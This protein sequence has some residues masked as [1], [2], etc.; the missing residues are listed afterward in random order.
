MTRRTRIVAIDA[1][2]PEGTPVPE[3]VIET[4]AAPAE[5]PEEWGQQDVPVTARSWGIIAAFA[6]TACAVIGWT[7]LFVLVNLPAMQAGAPLSQWTGWVR[8]WSVPVLLVAVIWLIAMRNSRR[9]ALRF[10][11]GL[12]R[13]RNADHCHRACGQHHRAADQPFAPLAQT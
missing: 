6:F 10:G 8:D 4:E 13:A 1:G 7:A 3:A 2:E 5:N 9:E 11:L 12:F